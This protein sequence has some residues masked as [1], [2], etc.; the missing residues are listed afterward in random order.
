MDTRWMFFKDVVRSCYELRRRAAQHSVRRVRFV[1]NLS[2]PCLLLVSF[3]LFR[4]EATDWCGFV[5]LALGAMFLP[6]VYGHLTI[7]A[8]EHRAE[9]P[10]AFEI[11][12]Q[13][14]RFVRELPCASE[15]GWNLLERLGESVEGGDARRI[16]CDRFIV[17]GHADFYGWSFLRLLRQAIP[18]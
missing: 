3:L 16:L 17:E 7:L 9:I 10:E 5:S 1:M 8:V 12:A 11:E 6:L 2:M 14:E 15:A 13:A 4:L 18:E